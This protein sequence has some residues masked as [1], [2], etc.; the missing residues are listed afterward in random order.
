MLLILEQEEQKD[1]LS[2]SRG[3]PALLLC[4]D[5]GREISACPQQAQPWLRSPLWHLSL[6]RAATLYFLSNVAERTGK[7]SRGELHFG[8]DQGHE[9]L[10]ASGDCFLLNAFA[11]VRET[12][13]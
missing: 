7:F 6:G 10:L 1:L 8:N 11:E 9:D 3:I 13:F 2:T 4:K 12:L 5:M